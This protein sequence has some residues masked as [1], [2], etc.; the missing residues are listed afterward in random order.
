MNS[1]KCF[2]AIPV[3][4]LQ[5]SHPRDRP[6][7]AMDDVWI[8]DGSDIEIDEADPPLS[9]FDG[10]KKGFL[11]DKQVNRKSRGATPQPPLRYQSEP[12]R[13]RTCNAGE[14]HAKRTCN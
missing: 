14:K 13:T 8:S 2:A 12:P 4:Q 10:L 11:L 6:R 1:V 7:S 9:I 3:R 5:V